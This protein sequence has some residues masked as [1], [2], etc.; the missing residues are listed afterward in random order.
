M[1]LSP[2]T[3]I[4]PYQIAAQIGAGGMGE[5]YKA[6]DSRLDRTVAIKVL[7]D[8]AGDLMVASYSIAGETRSLRRSRESG[9]TSAYS[10][11]GS[12]DHASV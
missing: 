3:R 10:T 5:V 1:T 7:P 8:A 4:G 9:R 12:V 11:F 6:R 2:G